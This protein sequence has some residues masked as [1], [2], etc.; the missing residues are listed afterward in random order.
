MCC[1]GSQRVGGL[2]AMAA[3]HAIAV[4]SL[5]LPLA[6]ECNIAGDASE[7]DECF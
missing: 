1:V 7:L 5:E 6:S 3:Q 2:L 4:S